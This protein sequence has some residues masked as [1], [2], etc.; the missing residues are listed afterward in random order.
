[1]IAVGGNSLSRGLTLEGLS[2]S[3]FFRNSQMYDT[4]LQMGRWFGYR[5]GYADLCRLWLTHEAARWYT[6]IT[7]ATD[8]LRREFKHMHQLAL[9][10]KD[11]G[12]KV[13][14]HPDSLIVTARNK[15]RLAQTIT[16]EISLNQK[17]IETTRLRSNPNVVRANFEAA[18]RFLK[19]LV[20]RGY[21]PVPSRWGSTIWHKVP[22]EFIAAFLPQFET[23]PMNYDFQAVELGAFLERTDEPKLQEWD[24]V[25]PNGSLASEPF[26]DLDVRPTKRFIVVRRDNRSIMVSGRSSRVGSRGI[27]REGL[28]DTQYD[29]ARAAAEG[30]N[31]SDNQFREVRER[32]LLL[33]HVLRG[34]TRNGAE[35]VTDLG[36]NR[37]HPPLVALGLSFPAFDD[38]G[39]AG[40]VTYK[41]NTIEWRSMFEE[42]SDDDYADDDE[43]ID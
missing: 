22:K 5:D 36:L 13:R 38:S 32:P 27:E 10:P 7:A 8:E 16:R 24:V 40:R 21:M 12:L 4:L 42:E 17:G 14:A 19:D 26:G 30:K 1:V 29:I 3:Y 11:F 34:Y 31:I 20:V 18:T 43:P 15:M 9:T 39:I 41:V 33:I 23:H 37:P 28:T 2:T 35:D 25:I 6:H